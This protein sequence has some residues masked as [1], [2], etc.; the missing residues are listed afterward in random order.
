M[1]ALVD[2]VRIGLNIHLAMLN[3]M[4]FEKFQLKENQF[5]FY[6]P[7]SVVTRDAMTFAISTRPAHF[8]LLIFKFRE[9]DWYALELS[10]IFSVDFAFD[11][12]Q[13]IKCCRT[14]TVKFA[15]IDSRRQNERY[16]NLCYQFNRFFLYFVEYLFWWPF[17]F[18][19][20]CCYSFV[21]FRLMMPRFEN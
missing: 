9:I 18:N 15:L 21:S 6:I 5:N 13:L 4:W 20:K 2:T 3:D 16:H 14:A 1:N 17:L 12:E 11:L 19:M 8:Y 10:S 7:N